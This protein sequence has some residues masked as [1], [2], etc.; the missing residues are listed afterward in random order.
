MQRLFSGFPSGLAG[1]ALLVLRLAVGAC[2]ALEAAALLSEG[3]LSASAATA[4]AVSAL[5]AGIFV[6]VG[7]LTPLASALLG[8]QA[9]LTLFASAPLLGLLDSRMAVLEFLVMAAVLAVLGPGAI[10]IDARMFGRRE[11]AIRR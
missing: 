2:A 10:S 5:V 7:F 11:V 9:A 6:I 8:T 1:L 4:V 3:H